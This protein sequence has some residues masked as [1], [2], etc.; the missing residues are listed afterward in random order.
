MVL[1]PGQVGRP[2]LSTSSAPPEPSTC[3]LCGG[4]AGESFLARDLNLGVPDRTFA[5]RVCAQCRTVQIAHIPADLAEFY[6]SVYYPIPASRQDL[7]AIAE[8]ERFKLD[9]VQ[10][11]ATAGRLLEIGPAV[12]GFALLAKDAG[13]DV[14]TVEMDARCCEFLR[15][16][17]GVKATQTSD[18][19]GFLEDSGQ[20]DVIALWHVL[21]HLPNP[22]E[23]L[24]AAAARL[25][26]GGILV[27]AVPNPDSLQF[28]LFKTLWAHL[29]APRHLQLIPARAIRQVVRPWGLI[30]VVQTTTDRGG[31]GWNVFGWQISLQHLARRVGLRSVP[32]LTGR[33]MCRILRPLER[34]GMRGST[35]T[36]VLRKEPS[37]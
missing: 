20:F 12:G 16:T 18:A 11:F 2:S 27:V 7:M 24:S 36:L 15:G 31:L 10:N 23:T 14:E 35:Y 26:E 32:S 4:Q 33:A 3:R 1:A 5:Y 21:E 28:A 13:F 6:P 37:G 30:P 9:I 19:A 25:S 34:H 8:D 17:V 29:D 22:R